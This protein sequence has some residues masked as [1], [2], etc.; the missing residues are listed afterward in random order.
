MK[1][2]WCAVASGCFVAVSGI[3][4]II[5]GIENLFGG[6]LLSQILVFTLILA[7]GFFMY[8]YIFVLVTMPIR[9]IW[10]MMKRR[11]K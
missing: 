10:N 4:G 5:I 11:S 2:K 1:H 6:A 8:Y 9:F 3:G 7:L